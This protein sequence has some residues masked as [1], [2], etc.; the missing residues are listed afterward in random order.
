MTMFFQSDMNDE[1]KRY[2]TFS[3]FRSPEGIWPLQLAQAGFFR[4]ANCEDS[5]VVCFACGLVL[6]LRTVGR[7]PVVEVHRRLSPQCNFVGGCSNNQPV[8]PVDPKAALEWLSQNFSFDLQT[9]DSV[10]HSYHMPCTQSNESVANETAIFDDAT[11]ANLM[12][13]FPQLSNLNTLEQSDALPSLPMDF[14]DGFAN[15]TLSS[16]PAREVFQDGTDTPSNQQWYFGSSNL[17]GPRDILV[18]DGVPVGEEGSYPSP[19]MPDT[20]IST[21]FNN[22]PQQQQQLPGELGEAVIPQKLTYSDLGIITQ[23]PKREEFAL[24]E[25]RLDTFRDWMGPGISQSQEEIAEAGFYYAGYSDCCRCFYCGGGLKS[26][27][28]DDNP[29]IEHARWFKTCPFILTKKG[30]DF[31]EAVDSLARTNNTIFM[32][33]VDTEMERMKS[34]YIHRLEEVV[35]LT[36][37]DEEMEAE[38][39]DEDGNMADE[40]DRLRDE[41]LSLRQPELCKICLDEEVSIVY[42]PCGHL[43]TCGACASTVKICPVCRETIGGQIRIQRTDS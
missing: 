6:D 9:E 36:T 33:D 2:A 27:E 10:H 25:R 12:S 3:G 21:F 8:P 43:V 4:S 16:V 13:N 37:A 11:L 41:N 30:K 39:S 32:L 17:G 38:V 19:V 7:D 34:T 14:L 24:Y 1:F 31:I 20:E 26:W 22:M 29:W 15:A 40:A 5:Q 18:T 42:V 35:D 23:R 28:P